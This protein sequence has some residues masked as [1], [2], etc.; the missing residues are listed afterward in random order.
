ME[1]SKPDRQYALQRKSPQSLP[2]E[3]SGFD[4]KGERQA[5][6]WTKFVTSPGPRQPEGGSRVTAWLAD[7]QKIESFSRQ[8]NYIEADLWYRRTLA[9]PSIQS[10]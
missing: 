9:S 8:A 10:V 2:G 5:I 7:S 1:S 4:L 6:L 3:E